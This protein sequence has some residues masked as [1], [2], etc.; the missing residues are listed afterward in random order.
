MVAGLRMQADSAKL[1][2]SNALKA[3]A[4]KILLPVDGSSHSDRAVQHA[5]TAA[6]G[7]AGREILLI[8]VQEPIDA[9]A[10]VSHMPMRE[11]EAM[12]QTRGGDALA[13]ARALLDKAGIE[14]DSAVLVGAV[15]ET[16]AQYARENGCAKIVI[17]TRG[18]GAIG[19]ALLGSVT[20]RLI[21][22]TELPVTLIK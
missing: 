16:I 9:P 22:L 2:S 21:A 13:S 4:M 3:I 5:I 20:S 10:L 18:L 6:G 11:I 19:G 12:Q 1:R 8:N 7:C 15:P 14:Y 17:G